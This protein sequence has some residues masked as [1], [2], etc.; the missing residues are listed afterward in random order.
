MK[1]EMD[2]K[3]SGNFHRLIRN[4]I[5]SRIRGLRRG[6]YFFSLPLVLLLALCFGERFKCPSNSG[7]ISPTRRFGRVVQVSVQ[8]SDEVQ[9]TIYLK[10]LKSHR[11]FLERI[12][13][14]KAPGC[15]QLRSSLAREHAG[16]LDSLYTAIELLKH[17][18]ISKNENHRS[19]QK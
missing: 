11:D 18:K 13:D 6:I 9:N 19:T 3:A 8:P 5:T 15:E 4:S 12:M 10:R 14:C 7:E 16:L 1:K 2:T 17:K